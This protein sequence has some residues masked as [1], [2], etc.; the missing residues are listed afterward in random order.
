MRGFLNEIISP[1]Q[2]A[3]E[4]RERVRER[5]PMKDPEIIQQEEEEEEAEE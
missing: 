3:S 5:S 1:V 2:A 4:T